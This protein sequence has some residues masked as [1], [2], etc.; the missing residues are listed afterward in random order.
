MNEAI[1]FES[2]SLR[3]ALCTEKNTEIL[4]RVGNLILLPDHGFA[5]AEQVAKFYKAPIKTIQTIVIRHRDELE[6]DGYRVLTRKEFEQHY[7]SAPHYKARSIAIFPRRSIL[8]VGMLLVESDVAKLVRHYL[9]AS[10]EHSLSVANRSDLLHVA[11]EL[12]VHAEKIALGAQKT[13]ENAA[14]LIRHADLLTDIIREVY[15]GRDEMREMREKVSKLE[16]RFSVW[17]NHRESRQTDQPSDASEYVNERQ[18][19]ILKQKVRSLSDKP[20]TVWRKFNKFFDISRYRFLP[21]S[22]F[23]DAVQWLDQYGD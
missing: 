4:Q 9:L 14:Q 17:E 23:D 11:K 16:L 12:R 13:S 20:I 21:A 8:R 22:K 2:V 6:H 3:Q 19:E 10:E 5:T 1:I 18:I 7:G 15:H